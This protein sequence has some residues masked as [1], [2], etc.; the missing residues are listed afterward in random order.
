MLDWLLHGIKVYEQILFFLC[1]T[2]CC[3]VGRTNRKS[4]PASPSSWNYSRNCRNATVA[5]LTQYTSG[6]QLSMWNELNSKMPVYK[7][8]KRTKKKKT[9]QNKQSWGNVKME[10]VDANLSRVATGWCMYSAVFSN[11]SLKQWSFSVFRAH[12]IFWCIVWSWKR[13]V[14]S[15]IFSFSCCFCE[16]FDLFCIYQ[17][18]VIISHY[19]EWVHFQWMLFSF[20]EPLQCI[21]I[22]NWN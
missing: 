12:S 18:L 20:V 13:D 1:R 10:S 7:K 9:Q 6:N 3:S 15:F 17:L 11:V 2:S 19:L 5:C 16:M 21:F 4:G 8:N 14:F 22:N